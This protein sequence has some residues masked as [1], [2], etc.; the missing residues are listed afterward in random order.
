[1]RPEPGS[2]QDAAADAAIDELVATAVERGPAGAVVVRVV[3]EL[4]GLTAPRMVQALADGL[5]DR[6]RR[7]VV[8]LTGVRFCGTGGIGA[9]L[10]ARANALG[11]GT[12]FVL[13]CSRWVSRPLELAGLH[14]L[15][16][17]SSSVRD[18]LGPVSGG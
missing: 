6:P 12:E 3:G 14:E 15:F 18:A 13:V 9:L 4:D 17:M 2:G 5:I 11:E 8:D 16:T 1:M 7:L 10:Q